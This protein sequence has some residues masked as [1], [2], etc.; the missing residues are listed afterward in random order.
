M[1]AEEWLESVRQCVTQIDAETARIAAMRAQLGPHAR[2]GQFGSATYLDPMRHV[3]EC[4][5]AEW[6]SSQ[7]VAECEEQIDR[8]WKLVAGIEALNGFDAAR[9]V[10]RRYL[11]AEGWP[12]IARRLG[13]GEGEC[14]VLCRRVCQW[15]DAVG[16]ARLVEIGEGVESDAQGMSRMID[17]Y[18][19]DMKAAR[20]R[21]NGR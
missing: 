9:I 12:Q 10:T 1:T 6:E 14:Q 17:L 16:I 19:A 13:H 7:I 20:N 15:I 2:G 8:A 18:I 3:D 11:C 4:L 21:S 5:D